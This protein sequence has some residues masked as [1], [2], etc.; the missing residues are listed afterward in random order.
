[1]AS[2]RLSETDTRNCL[3]RKIKNGTPRNEGATRG[4][5]VPTAP[6]PSQIKYRGIIVT[7]GGNTIV[8]RIN[9]KITRAPRHFTFASEYATSGQTSEVPTIDRPAIS[10]V[11]NKYRQNGI[12]SKAVRKLSS[13]QVSGRSVGG[14][15]KTS[16]SGLKAV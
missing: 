1:P 7:C 16:F 5:I 13:V 2:I 15:E 4:K 6:T 14:E 8:P 10:T 9:M 11:L 3:T 12:A